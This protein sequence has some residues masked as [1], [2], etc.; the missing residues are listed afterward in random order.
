MY[1]GQD[2][3]RASLRK[4]AG[5][6]VCYNLGPKK[7]N[8]CLKPLNYNFAKEKLTKRIELMIELLHEFGLSS[9]SSAQ[10]QS[11]QNPKGINFLMFELLLFMRQDQAQKSTR[12]RSL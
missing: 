6:A 2:G 9:S 5:S 4:M 12:A 3:R 10:K 1:L 7:V 8:I 11:W